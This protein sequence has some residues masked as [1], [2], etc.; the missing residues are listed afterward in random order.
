MGRGLVEVVEGDDVA[1]A[2]LVGA[3]RLIDHERALVDRRLHRAARHDEGSHAEGPDPD[4]QEREGKEHDDARADDD[5][6]RCAHFRRAPFFSVLGGGA[7]PCGTAP[8]ES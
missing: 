2:E 4:E 7:V 8:E 5:L 6:D 3:H 1:E